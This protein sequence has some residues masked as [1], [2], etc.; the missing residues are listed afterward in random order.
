M[1]IASILADM[2]GKIFRI[3]KQVTSFEIRTKKLTT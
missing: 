2:T 1:H 3:N